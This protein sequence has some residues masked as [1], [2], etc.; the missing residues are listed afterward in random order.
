MKKLG[1]SGFTLLELMI[2]I[3]IV[4]ILAAMAGPSFNATLEKQR[5]ISAA[6]AMLADLRWARAEAIVRNQK[7]RVTFT[8]G[9]AWSYAIRVGPGGSNTLLKTV[10]GSDFPATTLASASFAGGVAYTTF[11]PIRGI[12][13][14]NGTATITSN[15]FSVGVKVST[16]GRARICGSIGGYEAC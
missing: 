7:I 12:N 6:E 15:H 1:N 11:D 9:G 4:A 10:N 14:N 8:T 3:A 13:P 5:L 2:V 16:L